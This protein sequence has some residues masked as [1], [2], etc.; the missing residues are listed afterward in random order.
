MPV[1]EVETLIIGGGQAGLTMSHCLTQRGRPHL[2]LE[3]GRIAERWRSQ[4]WDSLRFQ[5]PN[6]S[7]RLPNFPFPHADPDGFATTSEIVDYLTAY[8]AF[9]AAPVRCGVAVTS[10]RGRDGA[11]GFIAETSDGAIGAA[12]V[13]IATGPYQRPVIPSLLRDDIGVHQ[14]HASR[15]MN[16]DQLPAGAVLVVGCGPSGAQIAEELFRA[17]RGVFLS[18]GRHA[19]VPRRYR[20]RDVIWWM[21]ALGRDQI[22]VEE[23]GPLRLMPVISGADGGH[24]IDFRRFAIDGM[25]LLGRVTASRDGIVE[26]AADLANSLALGDA[27]YAFFVDLADA[28]IAQHG[29][30]FPQEPEARAVLP[31]SP[32]IAEPMRHLDL[33]A[34]GI[35]A[36]IWATGYVSDFSWIDIPV[37]G[38]DGEPRHR[39]GISE[40]TGLYF[41]G[42][43]WLSTLK[44][45]FLSGVGDD[46]AVLADHIAARS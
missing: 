12:N 45:S 39:R 37:L 10:L 5:L 44:S 36:V 20:G 15:Y 18:L 35:G 38:P 9:T 33:R 17:G 24:T 21:S 7:V 31:D 19:R 22:P 28:H 32:C 4:R 27:A 23:R 42:L 25:T 11:S 41:L 40:V 26:I 34:E 14:L 2:V 8:A 43:Q 1:D 6:W 30:S 16:P 3:Q 13:V 46:A 29:L